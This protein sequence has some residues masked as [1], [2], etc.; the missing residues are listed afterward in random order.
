MYFSLPFHIHIISYVGP[1]TLII[2]LREVVLI[3]KDNN[4]SYLDGVEICFVESESE[5]ENQPTLLR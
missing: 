3:F 1:L 5:S 4:S 2:W